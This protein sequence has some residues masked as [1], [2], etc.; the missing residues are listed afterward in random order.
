MPE[1]LSEPAYRVHLVRASHRTPRGLR[2]CDPLQNPNQN[3]SEKENQQA[4]YALPL[5]GIEQGA[6]RET[7]QNLP[8]LATAR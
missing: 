2:P 4:S 3:L 5:V 8:E 7:E 6:S 1:A